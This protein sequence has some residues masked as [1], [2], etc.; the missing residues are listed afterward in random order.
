MWN[1]RQDPDSCSDIQSLPG[2][3]A[4]KYG[5][6][7]DHFGST[8]WMSGIG[9]ERTKTRAKE[10][11]RLWHVSL[12]DEIAWNGEFWKC[13]KCFLRSHRL[14]GCNQ[15]EGFFGHT[16]LLPCEA[17]VYNPLRGH[18]GIQSCKW[19]G[20][21]RA[22]HILI[23]DQVGA[24]P[25]QLRRLCRG[26]LSL[27]T[28]V[29]LAAEIT[30][31][32]HLL[33]PRPLLPCPLPSPPTT[34]PPTISPPPEIAT[35]SPQRKSIPKPCPI[36][37]AGTCSSSAPSAPPPKPD[38]PAPTS[39]KTKKRKSEE[40][41]VDGDSESSLSEAESVHD[42]PVVQS[43]AGRA[44]R[45]LPPPLLRN[46]KEES[47]RC[48]PFISPMLVQQV[49]SSLTFTVAQTFGDVEFS[50]I[51]ASWIIFHRFEKDVFPEAQCTEFLH[52][53]SSSS[54]K[55]WGH[56]TQNPEIFYTLIIR[57]N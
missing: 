8:S 52:S 13:V 42:S 37:P 33:L 7:P 5:G 38:T 15:N 12:G 56:N 22:S 53:P 3:G 50:Q 6:F 23:L 47:S 41:E 36:R 40:L 18:P 11:S 1:H 4:S 54:G 14:G 34:S 21:D 49:P 32:P 39:D 10:F 25:Q 28:V 19:T 9:L 16:D 46:T 30:L 20:I 43:V 35:L 17:L 27:K 51:H 45:R 48:S 29:M 2:D 31:L 44:E 24:D 26:E 55:D 57:G